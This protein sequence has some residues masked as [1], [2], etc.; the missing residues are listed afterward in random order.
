MANSSMM[1]FQCRPLAVV[2]PWDGRGAVS[3]VP[4]NSMVEF[5]S[6]L[7]RETKQP[8]LFTLAAWRLSHCSSGSLNGQ[9]SIVLVG[10][11][12]ARL[13]SAVLYSIPIVF[14]VNAA[15]RV[16]ACQR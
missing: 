2:C 12:V 4:V 9:A 13:R 10:N 14:P 7:L 3:C 16:Q 11:L 5:R 8:G 15:W 6:L 1:E